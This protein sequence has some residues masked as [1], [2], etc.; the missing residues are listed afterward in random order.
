[1][2]HPD[3][4][5]EAIK[6]ITA[7]FAPLR[8]EATAPRPRGERDGVGADVG[9]WEWDGGSGTEGWGWGSG[10]GAVGW[11]C[12]ETGQ[13]GQRCGDGATGMGEMGA[14][15]RGW[16]RCGGGTR[17]GR[18]GRRRRAERWG[19]AMGQS[20]LWVSRRGSPRGPPFPLHP[21]SPA[22][23][24]PRCHGNHA[25]AGRSLAR[26][27]IPAP[28]EPWAVPMGPGDAAQPH[29]SAPHGCGPQPHCV[30]SSPTSLP[31]SSPRRPYSHSI[32]PS[33]AAP[34]PAPLR[35]P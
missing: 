9:R 2:F 29:C 1:M 18:R 14:E 26:P 23:P 10:A 31:P 34:P 20:G 12:G 32:V 22:V 7:V 21:P 28:P 4:A 6:L 3:A 16:E 25:V 35:C 30:A 19:E 15:F 5:N 24:I 8:A 27:R 17:T 33:P 13:W 11:R